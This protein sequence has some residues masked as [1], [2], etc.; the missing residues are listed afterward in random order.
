MIKGIENIRW[1]EI[2][3]DL[4]TQSAIKISII[5][6]P[7]QLQ[8]NALLFINKLTE[9]MM[10]ALN[11][12]QGCLL[13]LN[14]QDEPL[15][16]QLKLKHHLY[17][18]AKPRHAYALLLN[19]IYDF[20]RER[21]L[22]FDSELQ[23]YKGANVQ[24]HPKAHIEPQ[25]VIYAHTSIGE[26]AYL[27]S[28]CKIGPNVKVGNDVIIRENSIIGGFGFG[29]SLE[30]ELPVRIPHIGGVIIG[31]NVE[32]GALNTVCSGAI[33]PTLIAEGV[34]TD[35]HVHIAH[36][37]MIEAGAILTAG[38]ILSGSVH[39]GK[40][41]WIGPNASIIQKVNI[42]DEAMIGIGAVVTKD[43]DAHKT[44]GAI[45]DLALKEVVRL[46]KLLNSP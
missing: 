20:K 16:E 26:G 28:G 38:V 13:I 1:Q 6:T 22:Q 42:G 37:C 39:V 7:L 21:A 19:K 40:K 32:I 35:D 4:K 31:A 17:F 14:Q 29:M 15:A 24:I 25:A 44:V 5:T 12:Y 27:M 33:H 10:V 3:P 34:K 45:G 43:V 46:K 41:V 30:D 8:N 18:A 36:N 11:Q 9:Q 23:I 2:L